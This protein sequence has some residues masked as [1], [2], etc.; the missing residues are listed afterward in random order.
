MVI[1]DRYDDR[2]CF[3]NRL[4]LISRRSFRSSFVLVFRQELTRLDVALSASRFVDFDL[5]YFLTDGLLRRRFCSIRCNR[6]FSVLGASL[7]L[8][9]SFLLLRP[10]IILYSSTSFA[11]RE[12]LLRFV[13]RRPC[14][15]G[16]VFGRNDMLLDRFRSYD[17]WCGRLDRFRC[18]LCRLGHKTFRST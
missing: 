7:W 14:F 12:W 10:P 8:L 17:F 5:D 11:L 16:S 18:S 4:Y 9:P 6:L 2:L 1:G 13:P 3:S 15:Q